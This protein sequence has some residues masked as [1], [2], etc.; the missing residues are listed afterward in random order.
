MKLSVIASSISVSRIWSPGSSG[1]LK[2]PIFVGSFVW[3]H[4]LCG[5][6]IFFYRYGVID[7]SQTSQGSYGSGKVREGQGISN[8]VRELFLCSKKS[9]KVRETLVFIRPPEPMAPQRVLII[10]GHCWAAP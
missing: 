3:V 1:V 10:V 2:F 8:L 9:G 6:V 4:S 7:V 5:K